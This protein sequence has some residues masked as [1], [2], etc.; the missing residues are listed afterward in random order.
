MST[1]VAERGRT[2]TFMVAA[3][4]CVG[5]MLAFVVLVV[6]LQ[7]QGATLLSLVKGGAHDGY[8]AEMPPVSLSTLLQ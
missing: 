5:L 2:V 1:P 3:G 7:G 4:L 8:F 6:G